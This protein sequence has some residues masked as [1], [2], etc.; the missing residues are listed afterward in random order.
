LDGRLAVAEVGN[1]R[2]VAL[3]P[4]N[5][6]AEPEILAA[7]LPL[8]LPPFMGPP[9]TFL[10]TGVIVGKDGVIYVTADVTHTVLKLTPTED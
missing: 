3:D 1:R 4:E 10:P 9:K 8:G 5:P 7:D 6:G 2:I